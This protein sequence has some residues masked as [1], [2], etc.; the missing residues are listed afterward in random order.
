MDEV[1]IRPLT[2][3]E[4]AEIAKRVEAGDA[5]EA[6]LLLEYEL[7]D[8]ERRWRA[9]SE[10]AQQEGYEGDSKMEC[11]VLH[12]DDER[13][14]FLVSTASNF[15]GQE[16]D[17]MEIAD[18]FGRLRDELGM[19][20]AAI[21]RFIGKPDGSSYAAGFLRLLDLHPDLRAQVE[22]G[23]LG[24]SVGKTLARVQAEHQIELLRQVKT[25][26]PVTVSR[27]TS[28]VEAY[29][30]QEPE[31]RNPNIRHRTRTPRS[32]LQIYLR[33]VKSTEGS[34]GDMRSDAIESAVLAGLGHEADPLDYD[35][36]VN[37]SV[38][39]AGNMLKAIASIPGDGEGTFEREFVELLSRGLQGIM[40]VD[41]EF[42]RVLNPDNRQ[43]L[44]T[45]LESIRD[46]ADSAIR[47]LSELETA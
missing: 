45:A 15:G 26:G 10:N 4:K 37:D 3:E 39:A 29:L 31:A 33:A 21:G 20:A 6:E 28:A 36:L 11:T 30:E 38:A 24:A 32:V 7:I 44:R 25:S 42:W 18:A 47:Q 16:H 43:P 1:K 17:P 19:S 34:F 12:L 35:K 13:L 41:D 46:A 22:D 14:Q 5:D 27:M 9:T 23:A 2:A 8:G 40:D